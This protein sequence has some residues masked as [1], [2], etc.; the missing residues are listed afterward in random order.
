MKDTCFYVQAAETIGNRISLDFSVDPPPDLVLEVAIH[1]Y[2]T[3]N[4]AIYAA[5]GVPEIWR[6]DDQLAMTIHHL[7]QKE[8]GV[9]N[10]DQPKTH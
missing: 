7:H 5:L 10:A 1:H 2:S 4:D 3:D 8:S 9:A 6:Y